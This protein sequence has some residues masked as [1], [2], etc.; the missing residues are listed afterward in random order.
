MKH[1]IFFLSQAGITWYLS[2][3]FRPSILV[4]HDLYPNHT[5]FA[6]RTPRGHGHKISTK[7]PKNFSCNST[8]KT[9]KNSNLRDQNK[10]FKSNRNKGCKY[11]LDILLQFF[12]N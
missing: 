8:V 6:A 4:L 3:V 1:E 5:E 7:H 2:N 12:Q 11:A 10:T 9:N